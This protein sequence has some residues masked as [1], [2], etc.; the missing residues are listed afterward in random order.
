MRYHGQQSLSGPLKSRSEIWRTIIGLFLIAGVYL[1]LLTITFFAVGFILSDEQRLV[2]EL[3]LSTLESPRIVL[4][5]LFSFLAMSIAVALVTWI[6]HRSNV[7]RLIGPLAAATG[8]FGRVIR[9]LF[10]LYLALTLLGWIFGLDG[11]E[12]EPN[13]SFSVWLSFLPFA[14]LGIFIQTG[15]EELAFRGY[16]QGF[17]AARFRSPLIWMMVPSVIFALGHFAPVENGENAWIIVTWTAFFGL[18]AADLTARTGNIGAAVGFHFMNNLYALMIISLSGPLSGLA[19][20]VYPFNASEV[21]LVTPLLML[22]LAMLVV[23]WLACR[24][25]C[26]V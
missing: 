20:Y 16:L 17:L 8:D 13:L 25:A 4:S 3:E 23:S 26:R 6:L 7:L 5:A 15:S 2:F 22:D 1:G 11:P 9:I 21:E 10:F 24:V 12:P 14:I 19:L 18:A